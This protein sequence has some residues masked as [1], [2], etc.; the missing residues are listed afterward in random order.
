MSIAWNPPGSPV[1]Y[2]QDRMPSVM[3]QLKQ[4][5]ESAAPYLQLQIL[6]AQPSK[7]FAG[8]IVYAD[9]AT[10]NPGSGEGVYRRDKTNTSW[11][12]LG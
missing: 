4:G 11:V 5:L 9:G 2:E 10:W 1:D 6:Y 12:H 8:M 7:L 3:S